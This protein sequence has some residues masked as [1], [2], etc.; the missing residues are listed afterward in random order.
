VKGFFINLAAV[1]LNDLQALQRSTPAKTGMGMLLGAIGAVTAAVLIWAV[2]IRKREDETARRYREHFSRGGE[3]S[4]AG[5][6][7]G[8]VH[9]SGSRR[10][11]K[12]RREHR[13]RN[14]TLAETG[15]LP[16]I[17]DHMPTDDPP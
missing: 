7:N 10:K 13:Q 6:S 15:G 16:P 9:A 8:G 17:R 12:R 5:A 2:F 14:P 4:P 3:P 1:D 11:R